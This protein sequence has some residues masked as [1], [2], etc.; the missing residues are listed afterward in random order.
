MFVVA[1]A[2]VFIAV[3]VGIAFATMWSARQFAGQRPPHLFAQWGVLW[4][5]VL[6][7]L[8]GVVHGLHLE[9]LRSPLALVLMAWVAGSVLSAIIAVQEFQSH[10]QPV[11]Q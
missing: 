11:K 3:A 9:D 5:V 8:Y 10:R 7:L 4:L 2:L 1:E 6:G